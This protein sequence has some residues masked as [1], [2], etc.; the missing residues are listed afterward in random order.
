MAEQNHD[1]KLLNDY[2]TGKS[3][4]SEKYQQLSAGQPHPDTDAMI[5]AAAK[6]EAH[7]QPAGLSH[8]T[9]RWLVPLAIAALLLLG[10]GIFWQQQAPFEEAIDNKS[11]AAPQPE[12]SLP[13]QVEK[14]LHANPAAEQW[15]DAILKLHNAGNTAKAAAE[16]KKFRQTY[17][18]YT[19]DSDRYA[20]L[21]QYDN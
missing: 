12:T 15:L 7:S 17:P 21:L 2:L 4:L 18:A 13:S 11:S 19:I 5:L 8:K 20:A 1:D 16:F 10:I 9:S 6:R 3:G 14:S